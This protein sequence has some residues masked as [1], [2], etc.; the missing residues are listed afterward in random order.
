MSIVKGSYVE[1]RYQDGPLRSGKVVI[2]CRH[3]ARA[4]SLVREP[5]G[6]LCDVKTSDM[7]LSLLDELA[8]L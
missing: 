5:N 8:A 1:W 7:K 4:R 6:Q 2:L 3:E